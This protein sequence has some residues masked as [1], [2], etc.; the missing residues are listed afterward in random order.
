M[1]DFRPRGTI[2]FNMSLMKSISCG[3]I[4]EMPEGME[5]CR[6]MDI[7]MPAKNT[8]G[9]YDG[10]QWEHLGLQLSGARAIRDWLVAAV[11]EWEALGPTYIYDA[12]LQADGSFSYT[13]VEEPR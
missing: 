5:P 7:R 9:T 1:E 4:P 8:E 13:L 2:D 12:R 3:D 11:A 10:K 6:M